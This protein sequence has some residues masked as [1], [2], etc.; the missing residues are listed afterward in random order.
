MTAVALHPRSLPAVMDD[1]GGA[2]RF[3][4]YP[5][6]LT[7]CSGSQA[8]LKCHIIGDPSPAVVWEKAGIVIEPCGRFQLKEDGDLYSLLI[9]CVTV[10]DRGQ[11]TCKAKNSIGETYAAATLNVEGSTDQRPQILT[12]PL[13]LKVC[14]GEDVSFV[15]EVSGQPSPSV[16]WEKDGKRLSDV[17]ETSHFSLENRLLKI[18]NARPQ[19]AGIYVCRAHNSFGEAVAVAVLLV[20]P[21]VQ[22]EDKRQNCFTSISEQH[23]NQYSCRP[24]TESDHRAILQNGEVSHAPTA[25]IFTVSEG[26]HAKFRCYVT[27]KPQP[28]IVWKKDGQSIV[29]GRRHL[30]YEDREGYFTLKVLYCQQR[31][32]GLYAC[33]ASNV[34]GQT[35]SAVELYV[36]EPQVKFQCQLQDAVV[37]ERGDAV[38]ECRVPEASM[39]TT[40]YMED[41]KLQAS[42]KYVIEEQDTIRRLTI[43]NAC[44]DDD[45]IYLCEMKGG[46]RNIAEV[47]VKGSIVKRLPTKLDVLEGENAVLCV[48]TEATTDDICWSRNQQQIQENP[49]T[50]L[51]SFGNTHLLVLV[52]V[53]REDAGRITFSVKESQTSAQLRVKCVARAPPGVPVAVKM[54][55]KSNAALLSWCPPRNLQGTPPST[56]ILERQELGDKDWVNC[57]TTDC[58]SVVE[59]Q[60]ESVPSEAKYRFRICSVNKYGKSRYV[61]FPGNIHL[62]PRAQIRRPLQNIL[63]REGEDAK[64]FVELSASVTGSWLV[65]GKQVN[66]DL[67]EEEGKGRRCH[68]K[69]ERTLH[70]MLIEGAHHNQDGTEVTFIAEGIRQSALLHVQAPQVSIM[71]IPEE[72]RRKTV[73]SGQSLLLE[74]EVSSPEAPVHWFRDG[75]E[76]LPSD[77]VS[78]QSEGKK[79][80]LLISC[81]CPE[82][83][84]M[85]KC[86]A[87]DDTMTFTVEVSEPPVRIVNT[88]D[89]AIQEYMTGESVVLSCEL[90][91]AGVLVHWYQDGVEVETNKDMRV[92]SDGVHHRLIIP[93]AKMQDSGEFVCDVGDDSVFYTVKVTEPPVRIVNTSDDAIQEYMTGE[94][95]VLSCE[96][97]RAG[98]LVHWYQDG[99]E[100]ETNKDMRVESDGVHHRLIIPSAK[101]Q[102]SGEFVC[103][104]GDDSVFYTVKVTEPP[105]RIV[106]TSDDAIQEYMTG[107]SV[108]LSCELSR[109]S[110]LVHWYKDGVEVETNEDMRV[111]SDGVHHR[112]I[113]PS[114]KM[115]DSGEFVCD[116]GDDSVFYTVKVTDPVVKIVHPTDHS[117]KLK[118]QTLD[119]IELKCELS[120]PN[121][122]VRWFKDGLEVNETENLCLETEGAVQHL[123]I[124]SASMED[125]GEYIC[126]T[127]EDSVSFDVKVTDPAVR[128]V[129]PSDHIVKLEFQSFD[130]IE[131][132]CELSRPNAEVCWFKDGLEVDETEN[133]HLE[134][135]G[136]V[137]RLTILSA[138]KEDSGEYVCDAND[139]FV[140][141]D[142]KV[143]EPLVKIL[144]RENLKTRLRCLPHEDLALQVQLSVASADLKW[145]KD[146]EKI[147]DSSRTH[148]EEQGALRSLLLLGAENGDSGEYLCVTNDDNCIFSVTVE[149]PPVHIVNKENVQTT[150][151][152]LQGEKITLTVKVSEPTASVQWLRNCQQLSSGTKVQFSNKGLIHVLIIEQAEILDSGTYTCKTTGDE[153]HFSVQV[154]EGQVKFVNKKNTAEDILALEGGSAMLV[155]VLSKESAAITWYRHQQALTTGQKYE[156]RHESYTH[157]LV[158]TSIDREDSGLY[159]CLSKDD[160]MQF[161]VRVKELPVV[162]TRGLYD[163][164]E[165]RDK[166]IVFQ[167]ELCKVLGDV[168]WIKDGRLIKPSRRHI[169]KAEGR[170]RSLTILHV[171]M[172]DA[173]EYSCESK[174][175]KTL[176][177]LIVE[178]PR[179][180][181]FI[182]ELHN[183]TVLEGDSAT[184][185]CVVSPEDVDV[186][187][188]LN[189]S[190][191]TPD[192]KYIM[193]RNG[194]CHSLTIRKCQISDGATVTAVADGI[195]T[196]ARLNVQEA[197]VMFRKKLQNVIAE[198]M[199]DVTLEVE[200]SVEGAEVQWLKQGVVIQPSRK[201][202]LETS[203]QRHMLTIHN[204]T[205]SDRGNYRCESLHDKTQARLCV[206]ARKVV[207]RNPLVDMEVYEKETV[208]FQ[209]A[210]SHP[211]VE[212]MW[213]KD[214]IRVKPNTRVKVS[215]SGC[216]HSL[217]LSALLLEDSGNII[218]SAENI[219]SSA[220]LT[221]RERPV[222]I[223]R[224]SQ[225]VGVPETVGARFECELSRAAAEV[226]WYK[227]GKEIEPGPNCRIYSMGR[228]RIV[229]LSHCRL[230]DA[231]TYTCDA[232]DCAVSSTLQ[233]YEREVKILKDIKTTDVQES[234]SAVFMCEVSQQDVGGE[235]FKNGENLKST[236]RIKIRQEGSK[237][238]LL[239]CDIKD[240]DAGEI[241]FIAKKAVSK[242][243]LTVNG[244]TTML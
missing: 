193:K 11:Y 49:R 86:D 230:E 3:L 183:I 119:R 138:T 185:K 197:Q 83:S 217:T 159:T 189:G 102:D 77:T 1:F 84:G 140:S 143:T 12:K 221:V 52:N 90:S 121:A 113:I 114:A 243:Q 69:Q 120:H 158:V 153:L 54:K 53:T 205:F 116:V 228:R 141:F 118:F 190:A 7:V 50:V 135:E 100:V 229:Q 60:G 61:E 211:G 109:A 88:S 105:V 44:T 38:L 127:S 117:V 196:K 208:T 223:I 206:D 165:Q 144:G 15:C 20:D 198:E 48:E 167:C 110:V 180:V 240:E 68:V 184:F 9:S 166:T 94:S 67:Q 187:W 235:W 137:Q 36:K 40:W 80:N 236:N 130:R 27:G 97:S 31:D 59:I 212:G 203:G 232:G 91:R 156:M 56:F 148:V 188:L 219:R 19:D 216:L 62:V 17:F 194:M 22:K 168:M 5:R 41:R 129:H 195:I 182:S 241:V 2:P 123:H 115:Q 71:Q 58:A 74:C 149:E 157:S 29:A 87:L 14:Q 75:Q 152:V 47:T 222:T 16:S 160:Q 18:R 107:E 238:F 25:K 239:I 215:A 172:A 213:I 139:D 128:I 46:G 136:P 72:E 155:A 57:F 244:L 99:V 101:M 55:E 242:A 175:D 174:D 111:E 131:L 191:F 96:L 209:L 95:V 26:K 124:L 226:K 23:G 176:A 64:F 233:V 6:T 108:V 150:I 93:S 85:Y 24:D 151:A 210:L 21:A 112:L 178:T 169:I 207:L 224:K 162:F 179:A 78:I 204:V 35:L 66:N 234:D 214:G 164:T 201:Y 28:E 122:E 142:V 4:A 199:Q 200:V 34:A 154:N 81:P 218:F 37:S 177:T 98:V 42:Q 163:L 30:L 104:V 227:D 13:S 220:K 171:D 82:D 45:G 170:E 132:K 125:S 146:G 106:N 134:Y 231:G 133:L 10:T 147:V 92:E 173:G 237:H 202:T 33:S 70:S 32:H 161:D 65:N 39:S 63:V 145:F 51:K 43:H 225:D 126:D 79:R 103:D 186:C 89:D 8:L 192:T 73:V 181:E 76:V